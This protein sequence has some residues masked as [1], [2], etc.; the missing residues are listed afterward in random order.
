MRDETRSRRRWKRQ[1]A[2]LAVI[3]VIEGREPVYDAVAVDMSSH[4]IRL[5]WSSPTDALFPGQ[6]V[7][8][9]LKAAS[10]HFSRARVVWVGRPGSPEHDQAG[11][12]FLNLPPVQ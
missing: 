3:I 4:G 1:H 9:H 11:F 12:E 6:V 8:L 2:P 5:Q 7:R 10:E